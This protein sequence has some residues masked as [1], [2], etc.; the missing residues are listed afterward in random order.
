MINSQEITMLLIENEEQVVRQVLEA[1][2]GETSPA[3]TVHHVRSAEEALSLLVDGKKYDI[4]VTDYYLPS[5]NGAQF[6]RTVLREIDEDQPIV[7]LTSNKDMNLVV[8]V[9]K[10]GVKDYLFTESVS[11][12]LF[13]KT[14]ISIV[15]KHKLRKEMEEL[16]HK[17]RRLGAMQEV[18]VKISSEI[19]EPLKV[20][21]SITMKLL[22]KS[23]DEKVRK[24]LSLIKENVERMQVK[25]E[26]LQNLK[27]DKTVQYIKDIRMIDLS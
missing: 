23:H 20:L 2:K 10:L 3:V 18:V 26:K 5:M 1:F 9:M 4:I 19:S 16:E 17:Q 6:A 24:Y 11:E 12:T 14:I 7:F 27:D 13:T 22:E 15:E 21:H 25:M 8:E